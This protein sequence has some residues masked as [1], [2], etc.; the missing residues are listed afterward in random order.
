MEEKKLQEIASTEDVENNKRLTYGS[1]LCIHRFCVCLCV[2]FSV[3]H[4]PRGRHTKEMKKELHISL[5]KTFSIA[6]FTM[7]RSS[8]EIILSCLC[9]CVGV[10]VCECVCETHFRIWTLFTEEQ[11]ATYSQI[12]CTV[13]LKAKSKVYF[14]ND[15]CTKCGMLWCSLVFFSSSFQFFLRAITNSC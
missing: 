2:C 4:E 11:P 15:L 7:W 1:I 10:C 8:M 6:L 14:S 5:L 13:I 9:K 12:K 3:S